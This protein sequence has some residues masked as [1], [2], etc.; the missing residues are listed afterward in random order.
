M[1]LFEVMPADR[2]LLSQQGRELSE[3]LSHHNRDGKHLGKRGC[4]FPFS[5]KAGKKESRGCSNLSPASAGSQ[6]YH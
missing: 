4:L 2:Q 5:V 3:Y 6:F 1:V